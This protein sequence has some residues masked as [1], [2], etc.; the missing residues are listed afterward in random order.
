M[1]HRY[2]AGA[3]WVWSLWVLPWRGLVGADAVQGCPVALPL[4]LV[5]AGGVFQGLL[6]MWTVTLLVNP[7]IVTAH[8][9]GGMATL[10]LGLVARP[11]SRDGMGPRPRGDCARLRPWAVRGLVLLCAQILLGG[12]TSTHYAAMG[13]IEFPTCYGGLWWPE[14]DFAEG[15]ALSAPHRA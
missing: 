1:V 3:P 8:L 2:L 9:A 12:W 4:I 11:G 13:C 7:S 6:G 10:G 14:T 15:F 5:G